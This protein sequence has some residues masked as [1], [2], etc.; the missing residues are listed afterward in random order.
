MTKIFLFTRY[1]TMEASKYVRINSVNPL[2][3]IFSK[4][5]VYFDEVNKNEYLTL[6]PTNDKQE[7]FEK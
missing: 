7:K 4:V 1:V 5:N 6:V 3:L 2:C